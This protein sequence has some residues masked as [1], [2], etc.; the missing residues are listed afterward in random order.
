MAD[1]Y[2]PATDRQSFQDFGDE[3]KQGD[4]KCC[5]D[6]TDRQSSDNGDGHGKLHR[7][8]TLDD[9]FVSF[10]EYRETPYEGTDYA[11]TGYIWI[12]TAGEKPNGTRRNS[13]KKD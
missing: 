2:A 3:N 13:A 7:H 9:V 10:V 12:P 1:C 6:F 5:E 11:D 4:D 8:A